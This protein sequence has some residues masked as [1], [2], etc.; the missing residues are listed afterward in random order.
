[1]TE[2]CDYL[3]IGGG[4]AGA[5]IAAR[6][7][8]HGNVIVLERET[9]PGYHST[10]RSAA[11]WEPS[12]GS[13]DVQSLVI[14]SEKFLRTPPDGYGDGSSYL[15]ARGEMTIFRA[16]QNE[17][18]VRTLE[19]ILNTSP[20]ARLLDQ[21]ETLARV[22]V[23]NPDY[24]AK[25]I[26]TDRVQDIDVNRLHQDYFKFMKAHNG[27]LVINAE[28]NVV[29]RASG[30][31]AW[32]VET[33]KAGNFYAPVV[34]NA[35]GAWCDEIAKL[36]GISPIGL[37]PRRRSAVLIDCP[38]VSDWPIVG[39]I[40]PD[41]Y[42][43]PDAGRLMLCPEDGSLSPPCDARPEEMDIAIAL[44]R[45]ERATTMK[46]IRPGHSWAGLRSFVADEM[47]V[48]GFDKDPSYSGFFWL[49][50]QGG[51]GIETSPATSLIASNLVRGLGMP[52]EMR[53]SGL[54]LDCVL[55][56]RLTAR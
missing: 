19:Q 20:D 21:K 54:T 25:S 16:D 37:E 41:F 14:A 5:S 17:L 36:A 29:N 40:D 33:V 34:V 11:S 3:V 28:V 48:A 50:G 32:Q 38:G 1:M 35:A 22:P 12:Y 4:I 27:R 39:A 52:D 26:Y 43:K 7:S 47:L 45:F 18:M 46:G 31:D 9:Q 24:V 6:L 55:P 30:A 15:S 8:E 10:G 42:F 56:N 23:L 2:Q 13:E 53:E 44:D 49:T 51:Y